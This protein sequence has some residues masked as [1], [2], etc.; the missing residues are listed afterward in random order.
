MMTFAAA[1]RRSRIGG[2]QFPAPLYS[3]LSQDDLAG[4][5]LAAV[6]ILQTSGYH[7]PV[8]EA[9]Q[10]IADHGGRLEGQRAYITP[11]MIER[12]FDS[13]R[14]VRL[15]DRLGRPTRL[16]ERGLGAPIC[17]STIADTFFV[18]DPYQHSVRPFVIKDQ[19]WLTTVIDALANIDYVQ[20][21]GQAEDVPAELQ[22]Q[23]AFAQTIRYTTKPILVYPYDRVGLLDIL[24]VAV[25]VAGSEAALQEK[26]FLMCAAVPAAPLSGT[27]YHLNL[28]LTCAERGIPVLNYN[29]PA[30]GGNSPADIV[31]TLVLST[32]DWL[33]NLVIHQLKRPGAP[34]CTAGFTVQLMD[35]KSTLWSYCAPETLQAYSAV[36]DIAHYYGLP[37]FGLEMTCD[38][39][40]IDA[41]MGVEFAAQCQRAFL[42]GVNMVHNAGIYG[43]GKLCGAE[44]VILADETIAY[45]RASM[46]SIQVTPEKLSDAVGLISEVG[47]LGEYI[48][49]EHT[50]KNFRNF[51]YPTIFERPRIDPRAEKAPADPWS[52]TCL[53]AR[54]NRRARHL[55]ETHRPAP[56]T[57][58]AAMAIDRL[59]DSWY[60]RNSAS[61]Q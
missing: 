30:L 3:V 58:E 60:R 45:T 34:F 42:S 38:C 43:A 50:L 48:S 46:Q 26:P 13:L 8:A 10:L 1:P 40:E 36:A 12:A 4:I 29:C 53:T 2:Q 54:L 35:M 23:L 61:G 9:R 17:F 51:W 32:A 37:A 41:Q 44:A 16:M 5:H 33:A 39:A 25:A 6:E 7:L 31:G 14:P 47:P 55:I 22:S 56:L 52:G 24:D 20:V 15:Y 57:A 27:D 21:V 11:E 28:L 19:C 18:Q 49:H 59:V